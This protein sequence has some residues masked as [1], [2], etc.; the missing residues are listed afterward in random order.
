MPRHAL[1]LASVAALL[2]VAGV[3]LAALS[4]HAEGGELGRTAAQF[5]IL[6]AA[7]LVGA[8]APRARPTRARVARRRGRA[9]ARAPLS[10][11][12]SAAGRLRRRA[13]V[14]D[15]RPH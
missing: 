1:L 10:Q 9:R 2:G 4:T 13:P 6:H 11:R 14:P 3:A 8:R 5:L 15:G 12:G 7:A